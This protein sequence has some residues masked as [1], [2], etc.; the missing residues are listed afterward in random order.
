MRR[1]LS[2]VCCLLLL[3]H[4][5][6]MAQRS[7]N[8]RGLLRDPTVKIDQTNLP[9][10]FINL[11][12]RMILRDSYVLARMK[13]I[14]NGEGQL[15]Y[16]DTIA[17]PGQHID[18]EGYIAL[19][20]RGN[21]S[22]D[23]SDKK[24]LAFRTL[25]TN[26]LPDYG[27]A[28][29]KVNI[30]GMPKD[31]KWAFIAP[32]SDE[33][34]IR[35]VLSFE[36]ARPWFDWVPAARLCEVVLD[37]YYYGVYVLCERV[38]KGKHRLDLDEPGTADG[39]LSGD[40]HVCVD[41]GYDPYY[42][43]KH[44][45]WQSLD[46]SREATW[47]TIK[48][49]YG[50]PEDED[51]WQLPDGTREALHNEIDLMEASFKGSDWLD[52]D[53]GYQHYIDRQ[54]FI[55]YMLATELS[56]NI[57][58]YRLSTHL[59]KHSDQRARNE[60]I[61][62]RWK[63][64]LWDFNIAWGNA[65]YY[66]GDRTDRWQYMLN[67]NFTGDNCPVPF[68]WYRLLQDPAYVDALRQR[69]QQYR[70]GNH[71]D[72]R[73]MHTI[74]SLTTLLQ[75]HGAADRNERAWAVYTRSYIWP[76]PYYAT[77]Y[78]DAVDHLK[79]WIE[80]RL[81]FLD[82]HLLPPRVIATQPVP[83]SSGWNEDIV[84][85]SLPAASY[86]TTPVDGSGRTLYA[87]QIRLSGSLP[88]NRLLVSANEN[89]NY[90]LQPYNASNAL[91][92]KSAGSSGT[93]TLQQPIETAELFVLGTSGNGASSLTVQL[94][95]ADGTTADAG[96]YELR[97]WSVRTEQLQGNEAVTALGNI[98]RD[99]NQYSSDNHYCLF[100]FS[101]PVDPERQLVS[102]AFTSNNQAYASVMALSQLV[103]DPSAVDPVMADRPALHR[104]P[105]AIY[106]LGGMRQHSAQRGI[107]IVRYSDG[108]TRKVVRK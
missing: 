72:E 28:K 66:D 98:R 15:N 90:E 63:T 58:G 33:T 8:Y 24:P 74:D 87:Q 26:M 11:D 100:D 31:N 65:N 52:P 79:S 54:S 10:V 35:D 47:Y 1:L 61:D 67:V 85:E 102:V 53:R 86:T 16:A 32:W 106:T 59:Y 64:T 80:R 50:D 107:S 105:S 13:I 36:L 21:S 83:V 93:L 104:Q 37:N 14:H 99:N 78:G 77:S 51:F 42:V 9:I 46:G 92:L 57:D 96:T 71:S 94:S 95:Y 76:I 69:W 6:T 88:A 44:H 62:P 25:E 4:S 18:Y 84:A 41:H 7:D 12:G 39:D 20:Y 45:P 43:S 91:T 40:Y 97:D 5:Y 68:Y 19:K 60:G 56:M 3:G 38:S 55:D 34:M 108:T 2:I 103:G 73:L 17:H 29:K 75:A 30:L 82:K 101:V 23:Q 81:R 89:V 48:Y 49:E 70:E 22:F 27:G